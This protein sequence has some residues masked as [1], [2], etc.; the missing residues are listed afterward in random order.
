MLHL[1]TIGALVE[2]LLGDEEMNRILDIS[3]N[4][5]KCLNFNK[6]AVLIC[7]SS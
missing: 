5:K 1:S 4:E 6:V 3:R 2:A 7:L